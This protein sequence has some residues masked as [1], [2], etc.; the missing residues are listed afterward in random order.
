MITLK[1]SL[2]RTSSTYMYINSAMS[3]YHAV[4]VKER[5]LIMK[6]HSLTRVMAF[7]PSLIK[8][9]TTAKWTHF[10][11]SVTISDLFYQCFKNLF[12]LHN[13][14][15]SSFQKYC[16]PLFYNDNGQ[17]SGQNDCHCHTQI[18]FNKVAEM[19]VTVLQRYWSMKW[20]KWLPLSYRDTM[21]CSIKWQEWLSLSYTDI[22]Q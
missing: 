22:I 2:V 18:L 14:G 20:P 13:I 6:L 15:R 7:D 21:Y 4:D 1:I 5:R 3:S 8:Q 10:G 11:D 9:I 16:T 19:I 12:C 17:R